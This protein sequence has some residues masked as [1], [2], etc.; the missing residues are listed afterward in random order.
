MS[1]EKPIK[2]DGDRLTLDLGKSLDY[3][4]LIHHDEQGRVLGRSPIADVRAYLNEFDI[5]ERIRDA[6]LY[7]IGL[8][9]QADALVGRSEFK[10]TKPLTSLSLE[11]LREDMKRPGMTINPTHVTIVVNDEDLARL[12]ADPVLFAER[13]YDPTHARTLLGFPV[14]PSEFV[15]PGLASEAGHHPAA[16]QRIR[17][18]RTRALASANEV[19]HSRGDPVAAPRR[20]TATVEGQV[21][22]ITKFT[23]TMN[24]ALGQVT[25][26]VEGEFDLDSDFQTAFRTWVNSQSPNPDAVKLEELTERLGRS[27]RSLAAKVAS[28]P[29]AA[30]PVP[31]P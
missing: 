24:N 22:G 9:P 4:E 27:N 11:Q 23:A 16:A 15:H 31:V 7:G 3:A 26:T 19:L 8:E 20:R 14:H 17:T 29:A 21:M 13:V 10:A 30:A 28:I 1:D 6:A 2:I 18:P 12:K 5:V 25:F